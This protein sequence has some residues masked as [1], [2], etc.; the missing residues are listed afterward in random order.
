MSVEAYGPSSQPLTFLDTEESVLLGADTQ[1]S[2]YDFTDFTLPSQTQTQTQ[3]RTQSQ[4]DNQVN[5]PAVVLQNG[6]DPVVKPGQLLAELNFEEDEEDAYYTKDL[7]LHACCYC[8]IHDPACVV[9]CNTSKKWFCNGRG[10]TS[11]SHIVNHLVRAKSKEVT[12]HKNGPLGETVLE[13]YNCG[14]RNVFL[15]GFIPAKADSVVVLLCRQPC[16]SQSG[17]KDIN[18]D[19]SQWQPLI[20]DRCFLSWLVK[21]PSEQEQLRARQITAQQINKLEEL[22]KENPTAALEDLEKPGVDEEPQ[23]VLLRYED[24]YQY[25]NIFGPLVKLEAD[26]DKKLKESQAAGPEAVPGRPRVQVAGPEAVPGRPRVQAAGSVAVPGRSSD[27]RAGDLGAVDQQ[28]GDIVAGDQQAGDVGADDLTAGGGTR[29][30]H[31][32]T[33]RRGV[34]TAGTFGKAV[35]IC[36]GVTKTQQVERV[37]PRNPQG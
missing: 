6:D 4:L 2:E 20:Q 26:Y 21:I 32:G 12:L 28:A 10:N 35:E 11:G 8:G 1:G 29:R 31:G 9:H 27:Q 23:H 3:G 5:G 25:Q 15:L 18:W 37:R 7:P 34:K 36:G 22:W 33:Q 16:A 14:C 17:L 19:S 13:C 30:T 24:A